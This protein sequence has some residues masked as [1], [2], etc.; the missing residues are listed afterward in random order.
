MKW[1]LYRN[2]C[3]ARVNELRMVRFSKEVITRMWFYGCKSCTENRF[4]FNVLRQKVTDFRNSLEEV[5][6]ILER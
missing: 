3:H 5:T 1:F 2:L 6:T 4:S